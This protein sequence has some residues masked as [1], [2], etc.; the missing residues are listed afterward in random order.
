MG[1]Q[2]V[3]AVTESAAQSAAAS[4]EKEDTELALHKF[5]SKD[6]LSPKKHGEAAGP[7]SSGHTK[8]CA[9]IGHWPAIAGGG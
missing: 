3:H 7:G 6:S 4:N 5:S 8:V 9:Q 1:V 2:V